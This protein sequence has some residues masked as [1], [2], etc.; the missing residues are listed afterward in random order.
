MGSSPLARGLHRGMRDRPPAGRIIPARAGFTGS[1]SPPGLRGGDHPRSRGVYAP[2]FRFGA[3]GGGSSPLARGLPRNPPARRTSTG[4]IPARAGFTVAFRRRA[5]VARDHP[6]SRGVYGL[7]HVYLYL[8]CGSSPLARGLL[9]VGRVRDSS[10]GI[11]PARAGFTR[12]PL[13]VT[14]PYTYHPRSR[15]VYRRTRAGLATHLGSSPLARGLRTLVVFIGVPSGIIPARAGFTFTRPYTSSYV[16]DH[17]RSRGVY[18]DT[19]HAAHKSPGSSPLA[20]GLPRPV[21]ESIRFRRIIPARAGF[22][23]SLLSIHRLPQ[24][25][26]RSRGV[27]SSSSS[28]NHIK[29]GSSPLARG[30]H[31]RILGIPTNP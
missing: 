7:A 11:I 19:C 21:S 22:T 13:G 31:L 29:N 8:T 5:R 3:D 27:Y 12:R 10:R 1:P 2:S 16:R 14:G 17:P 20:R 6:R 9:G 26:P 24:D 23:F 28:S 25:H 18:Q 4:I 30:L 15:G